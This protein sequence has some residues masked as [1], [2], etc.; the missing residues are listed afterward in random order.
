MAQDFSLRDKLTLLKRAPAQSIADSEPVPS[1]AVAEAVQRL[2]VGK[3]PAPLLSRTLP[4]TQL[5]AALGARCLAPGVLLCE[6]IFPLAAQHGSGNF[7]AAVQTSLV[8][9]LAVDVDYAQW[10][11]V[12]TETTGLAGGTGTIAFLLGAARFIAGE[13]VVRQ[14]LL[15]GFAGESALL[16]DFAAWLPDNPVLISYNGKSFDAPLLST[17]FRLMQL[18]DPMALAHH[19]D[20]VHATRRA[21]GGLWPDCRLTTVEKMLLGVQRIDDI[22]GADIPQIWF[23]L[24]RFGQLRQMPNVLQHNLLDLLSLVTLLP[25]LEATLSQRSSVTANRAAIARHHARSGRADKALQH[26]LEHRELLDPAGLFTLASLFAKRGD[27]AEAVAL[28]RE[29]ADGNHVEALLVWAKYA[30][31]VE[32]D[33]ALALQLAERLQ[34]LLPDEK[35]HAQRIA[36]LRRK[37]TRLR[38]NHSS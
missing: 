13:L 20:L 15:N 21:F 27:Y 4:D 32:K 5:A 23:D 24:V 37:T 35:A 25:A 30:E 2:R 28:W 6:K 33:F 38:H 17:R 29:L 18:S 26:L 10:V 11:F 14:Y 3:S 7:A 31:H 12:D 16:A 1:V 22:P 8:D 36:R 34:H 9:W 19:V